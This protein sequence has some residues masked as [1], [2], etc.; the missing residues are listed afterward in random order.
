MT[1]KFGSLDQLQCSTCI[2]YRCEWRQAYHLGFGLPHKPVFN[3]AVYSGSGGSRPYQKG[4]SI[5]HCQG[6]SVKTY[7]WTVEDS[8]SDVK[9]PDSNSNWNGAEIH[10]RFLCASQRG[11][12][13]GWQL[14]RWQNRRANRDDDSDADY[15]PPDQPDGATAVRTAGQVRREDIAKIVSRVPLNRSNWLRL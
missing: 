14:G 3:E 10:S 5:E 13:F 1:L 15:V 6:Y 9:S 11:K 12:I 4:T 8:I 2:S 7:F